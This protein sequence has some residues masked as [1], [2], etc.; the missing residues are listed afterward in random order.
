MN[1][2]RVWTITGPLVYTS[3][4]SNK[5]EFLPK[6]SFVLRPVMALGSAGPRNANQRLSSMHK[7]I[8]KMLYCLSLSPRNLHFV[9]VN[10][11]LIKSRSCYKIPAILTFGLAT[12]K[13]LFSKSL[14][15][16][17]CHFLH[18]YVPLVWPSGD[19]LHPWDFTRIS[20][21][22]LK[23]SQEFNWRMRL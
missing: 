2:S 21:Q 9:R 1:L 18:V 5:N 17:P 20:F 19:C 4:P 10:L 11:L 6:A 13:N 22:S 23:Q 16:L 12:L 15:I 3:P 8:L 7:V 14:D